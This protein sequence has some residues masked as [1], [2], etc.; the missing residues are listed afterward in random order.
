MG[1]VVDA[2]VDTVVDFVK[3]TAD[4]IGEVATDIYK[5]AIQPIA[6]FAV[7]VSSEIF[8]GLVIEPL[9]IVLEPI[10][11]GSVTETLGNINTGVTYLV[12]ETL[13]GNWKAAFQLAI[14]VGLVALTVFT[15][16]ATSG[17]TSLA[18]V[19]YNMGA[20]SAVVLSAVYYTALYVGLASSIYSL[21]G[22]A[23][24]VA[25][26]GAIIGAGGSTSLFQQLNSWADAMKLSFV[27]SWING[28]MN[29]YMAGNVLYD[30]PRAGDLLFNVTGSL[31]TTE[32]LGR[33]NTNSNNWS[34]WQLGEM[35][36]FQSHVNGTLA[37]EEFFA[38]SPLSQRM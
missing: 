6:D 18:S 2:V 38:V 20:T 17:A 31:N 23:I 26:L 32:F 9:E 3:D 30:A 4:F 25:E 15:M 11:L 8:Q 24:S 1:G 19:A 27:N 10:G 34:N 13:D 36:D 7:D 28:R 22:I 35:A 21:Y 16:G 37:G 14:I 5:D 12:H 29:L 33:P